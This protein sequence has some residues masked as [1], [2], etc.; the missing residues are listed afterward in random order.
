VH[1]EDGVDDVGDDDALDLAQFL[2]DPLELRVA[3]DE[4]RDIAGVVFEPV[5]DELDVADVPTGGADGG[6]HLSEEPRLVEDHHADGLYEL[7]DPFFD[8]HCAIIV[9]ALLLCQTR[10]PGVQSPLMIVYCGACSAQNFVSAERLAVRE[11][12]P[13]AGMRPSAAHR[14]R[15][16]RRWTGNPP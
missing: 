13:G 1:L 14:L 4:D 10:A 12:P 8:L 5:P 2:E 9:S 3:V 6:R 7:V 11:I 15:R 16:R